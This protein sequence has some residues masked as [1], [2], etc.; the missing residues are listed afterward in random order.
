[1]NLPGERKS[2]GP[3]RVFR[4]PVLVGVLLLAGLLSALL[5]D[6]LGRYFSWIA[7]SLP[8][9]ICLWFYLQARS[10]SGRTSSKSRP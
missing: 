1:M 10:R 9:S 8:V 5:S 3:A 6:G 7:L 4:F 2:N